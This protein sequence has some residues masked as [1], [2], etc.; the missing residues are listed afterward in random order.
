MI[1]AWMNWL[2]QA[3]LALCW[4]TPMVWLLSRF[5]HRQ[6]GARAGYAAWLAILPALFPPSWLMQL[7]ASE[8]LPTLVVT[9]GMVVSNT[10]L[11]ESMTS[12]GSLLVIVL[13]WLT[14][15]MIMASMKIWQQHRFVR[16]LQTERHPYP[17]KQTLALQEAGVPSWVRIRFS[18]SIDS[19]MV[20]GC[21][22]PT[23]YLP[24]DARP[25]DLI[26]A[27]EAAHLRHGDPF[28]T[29]LAAVLRCLYWFH[30]LVH[31]MWWRLRKDQE[32]AADERVL[33]QI[34]STERL[35]YAQL[36]CRASGL[37]HPPL[38]QA[39]PGP[40]TLKERIQMIS[41]TPRSPRRLSAGLVLVAAAFLIAGW[42]MIHAQPND[43]Q[44]LPDT[45]QAQ[46]AA[47]RL[48]AF[49]DSE[50][51]PSDQVEPVVRINPRYPRHAAEAGITGFVL[52]EA[53]LT[54]NGH[55][56]AIDVISSEPE[57]V[58][59]AEAI[60]AFSRWRIAPV[61]NEQTGQPEKRRIRQK[62]EFQLDESR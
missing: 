41:Q 45:P 47:A 35:H 40:S 28:W 16:F 24:L 57:G 53:T 62:I 2:V 10:G 22:P 7:S 13:I 59:D 3:S 14:G 49:A 5:L 52:M 61:R 27:H 42:S 12:T 25:T 17:C 9:P 46:E 56:T 43:G 48:M 30:P 37:V 60:Q 50:V 51:V 38:G 20:V 15:V 18:P 54:E 19:P 23:L 33:S 32:L 11:A 58:F 6:F 26:L 44:V 29:A 31:L 1:A 4:L 34:G 8:T 21:L 36:L 39:W 55:V